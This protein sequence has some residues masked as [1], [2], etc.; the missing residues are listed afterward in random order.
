M[1]DGNAAG[2]SNWMFKIMTPSTLDGEWYP[3]LHCQGGTNFRYEGPVL[4]KDTVT[5]RF[6]IQVVYVTTTTFR[7]HCRIYDTSGTLLYSDSDFVSDLSPNPTLASNPTNTVVNLASTV[8]LNAGSNGI[9]GTPSFPFIQSYQGCFAV[10]DGLAEG[11]TI[12]A[13]GSV[14]GE[15]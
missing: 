15:A 7:I 9:G 4:T 12:G 5:Y 3:R 14:T 1:Q 8:G 2:D 10:V 13:F 6:E 11:A